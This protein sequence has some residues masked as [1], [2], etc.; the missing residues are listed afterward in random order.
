MRARILSGIVFAIVVLTLVPIQYRPHPFASPNLERFIGFAVFG[1]AGGLLWPSRTFTLFL[2]GGAFAAVLEVAQAFDP[3]RHADAHD[4]VFKTL[5]LAA[6]L[7]SVRL[8]CFL[9]SRF[10]R[11]NTG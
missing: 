11:A 9:R 4:V 10:R 2:A 5:G 8:G 6:G 3:T 1:L 7:A